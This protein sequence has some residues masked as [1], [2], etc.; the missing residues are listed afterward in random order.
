MAIRPRQPG[1][2]IKPLTYVAAFEK[3]WT[4]A[5]LIWDVPSEFPP[6][7]NPSDPRPPYE[8]VNYDER[9]HGPVTVRTALANSYNIPAVKTLDF[10]GIFDDPD[11]PQADG[12]V[13]FAQRLGIST[14]DR[15][16][17]GLSLTLGG[18]DV[19]LLELTKAYATFANGGIQVPPVAILRIEDNTGAVVYS[20]DQ[21]S[22]EQLVR[23]EHAFLI[24]DILSDNQARTPAFGP[25]SLLN[26]P[27]KVAAKT[28]TTND[29][30]DNWTLGYTPDVAIGVWVGNADYTPMQNTSGLTGAA[31]I[32][33]AIMQFAQD[34]LT[35]GQPTPVSRPAGIVDRVV[36]AISGAEPS[37]W[38]PSQRTE[39]FAS[40]QLPL[41]REQDLWRKAWV[42]GFSLELASTDCAEFAE[43][44][45]GLNVSDPWARIWLEQ[46]DR[47]K[48]WLEQMGIEDDPL[49]LPA[50]SGL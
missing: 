49:L 11:T 17:Y 47:G 10:V 6:S 40:D 45:L 33:N 32:W 23:T 12:F 26:L 18:G 24:T 15:D 19:T 4:P 34:R 7:G 25:N 30:R 36:C 16:D 42:D 20:Y 8:P 37:E 35:G 9:F 5:T 31:P 13:A 2:S 44:K 43:E 22:G 29:F 50:R 48:D 1:S 38:C 46:D 41:P 21:P 39:L 3:G 28:G 14:L 27:F